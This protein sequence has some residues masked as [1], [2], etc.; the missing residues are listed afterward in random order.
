MF[1]GIGR[2]SVN[3]P[4]LV[5]LGWLVAAVALVVLAPQLKATSD[6]SEFLPSHYES[7]RAV[8]LQQEAF[9]QGRQPAAI[10]VFQRADG[11][12]LTDADSKDVV[13][14]A[15][16]L[17]AKD[18]P[19]VDKVVADPSAVSPD[20]K[21]ALGY[22]LATTDTAYDQ[23]LVESVRKLREAVPGQLKGTELELGLTGPAATALDA[24]EGSSR[25]DAMIMMATLVLIVV[26]LLAIFRSPVIALLPVLIIWLVF[27]VAMGV[28]GI[29]SDVTGL[30]AS[31]SISAILIVVLFGVGTDYTLFLLFRYRENL[32]QEQQ[33]KEALAAAAGRV[34]ETIASA[35]GAVIVAFLAL[36]LS[37]MG[38]LSN[39]GLSLALAVAVTLLAALTLVPAVFSLLGTKAF[40][41][42]KS[43]RKQPRHTLAERVGRLASRRA[44]IVAGVT[45]ALLAVMAA[46]V[47]GFKAEYDSESSMNSE[48]ES[49]QAMQDMRHSFAAGQSDPT[50]VYV[51]AAGDASLDEEGLAEYRTAL[52][53]VDGVDTVSPAQL[54]ET[55]DV[56]RFSVVLDFRPTQDQAIDL[57]AGDLRETAHAAAPEATEQYVGGT[58]AVLADIRDAVNRDYA[59]VFP[60]AALA[61]MVILALM[62][63][64]LVAPWFLMLSVGLG[65][66]GT[67]GATVWVFQRGDDGLLF[68]LPVIVY[69]F[70]VAIGTDYNI[71]MVA[72]LREEIREGRDPREAAALAVKQSAPTIGAAAVILAGTFGVL[73][74]AENSMLRQ[75]GFAV[76]FGILLSAFVMATLLV[77]ALTTLLGR[78]AW[79]PG[80]RAAPESPETGADPVDEEEREPLAPVRTP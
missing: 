53:G 25:T 57:V 69:L 1:Q 63:R 62:L 30:E 70:V 79:W 77:P 55:G 51:R 33:P 21:V 29:A 26:L 12:K 40:W 3:R 80:N 64:S 18:F 54:D 72:R 59:L 8:S 36:L 45:G 7:V 39:M 4:W 24:Q 28:I 27:L 47:L 32:R 38:M 16:G 52:A 17:Q 60:V 73:M 23:A 65:F 20:G 41:P 2:F 43:W 42:S 6:Q 71:L 15:S 68:M 22:V 67:L 19:K 48:L 46:G 78:K 49:V 11:G 76:A 50:M 13:E 37:S 56:A 74:L 9:P 35:A 61:I 58:T 31:S 75:M 5:T 34:G 66:G 14:V 44:P 10:A